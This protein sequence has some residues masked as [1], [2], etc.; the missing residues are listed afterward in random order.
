MSETHSSVARNVLLACLAACLV[1]V[2]GY[3][4]AYGPLHMGTDP[5]MYFVQAANI[6]H[7]RPLYETQQP[8][9][10]P[11]VLAA[12]HFAG[13]GTSRGVIALNFCA[14]AIGCAVLLATHAVR[15]FFLEN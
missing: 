1:A 12:L 5:V 9:G 15:L 11:L 13:L 3:A 14:L 6:V 8:L 4:F 7:G 2:Y 10:Y